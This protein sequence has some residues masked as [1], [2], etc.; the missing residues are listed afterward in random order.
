MEREELIKNV[1]KRVCKREKKAEPE[2]VF[3]DEASYYED[4]VIHLKE[5]KDPEVQFYTVIHE[6]THYFF[7]ELGHGDRF[8]IEL[9]ERYY[10]ELKKMP[11]DEYVAW[12]GRKKDMH[13]IRKAHIEFMDYMIEV[14]EEKE[15]KWIKKI[16]ADVA[17]RVCQ[18]G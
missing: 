11:K 10:K 14:L 2:L 3:D 13:E 9:G 16:G 15:R 5:E 6:L 17:E 18:E 7:P 12:F 1:V 8:S 4:G